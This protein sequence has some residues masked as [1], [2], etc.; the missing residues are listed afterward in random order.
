MEAQQ[1][2]RIQQLS[3]QVAV[4]GNEGQAFRQQLTDRW[5]EMLP[6][7]EQY[8]DQLAGENQWLHIP[9]MHIKLT[10]ESANQLPEHMAG[11]LRQAL[12]D[13][14]YE[15]PGSQVVE[16]PGGLEA[17]LVKPQKT[18]LSSIEHVLSDKDCLSFY[19]QKGRLPWYMKP[20]MDWRAV[21]AGLVASE[22]T[23]LI[24]EVLE[25]AQPAPVFRLL[26]LMDSTHLQQLVQIIAEKFTANRNHD[27]DIE[28]LV[29]QKLVNGELEVSSRQQKT[30]LLTVL[31]LNTGLNPS[32]LRSIPTTKIPAAQ[33]LSTTQARQWLTSDAWDSRQR[34]LLKQRILPIISENLADQDAKVDSSE[35]EESDDIEI[36][37]ADSRLDQAEEKKTQLEDDTI[38]EWIYMAGIILLH[39]YIPRFLNACGIDTST[40]RIVPQQMDRA[41]ALLSYLAKGE[42]R[43][44]EY[45]LELVKL[46]LGLELD[47]DL[48]LAEGMISERDRQEANSLLESFIS[49]WSQLK[50]TSIAGLRQAYLSRTGLLKKQDNA[51][52]LTIERTGIDVLL[53]SLPF[54]YSI[55]KFPWMPQPINV[56]W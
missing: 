28:I 26:A 11:L 15:H 14:K 37:P 36:S 50:G 16:G 46:L 30:W 31:M 10:V 38:A 42:E 4:R 27:T 12:K 47:D 1:S 17:Q 2:H 43:V 21:F 32:A 51:W 19:L 22:S 39:P 49:H 54:S 33:L 23:R 45:E 40:D 55:I 41:A 48:P 9:A 18:A 13:Q 52:L 35:L 8:F 25:T 7:F 5:Q 29:L 24:F 20:D 56:E 6:V 34:K 53:D 44:A 3:I